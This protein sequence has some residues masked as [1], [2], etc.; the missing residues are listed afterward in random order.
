MKEFY[1]GIAAIRLGGFLIGLSV[2][3][4]AAKLFG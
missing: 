2:G 3:L 4:V 1:P